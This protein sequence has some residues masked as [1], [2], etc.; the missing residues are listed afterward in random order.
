MSRVIIA[1]IAPITTHS[2]P[3]IIQAIR[4]TRSIRIRGRLSNS[5]S[6]PI[7][8]DFQTPNCFCHSDQIGIRHRIHKFSTTH[9]NSFHPQLKFHQTHSAIKQT[10]QI[11]N[12]EIPNPQTTLQLAKRF[13]IKTSN[14]VTLCCIIK[15][16][17]PTL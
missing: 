15:Q 17:K 9:F 12:L 1:T 3:Q 5:I 8:I 4:F 13:K 10:N 16:S 14:K 6:I 2:S 11:R 7:T